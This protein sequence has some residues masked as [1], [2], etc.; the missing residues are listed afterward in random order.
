MVQL[1]LGLTAWFHAGT[2]RLAVG[3]LAF[4]LEKNFRQKVH[5]A[6]SR[7][8]AYTE[9]AISRSLHN[10]R[11]QARW[12]AAMAAWRRMLHVKDLDAIN[13]KRGMCLWAVLASHPL[14]P[15]CPPT[16]YGSVLPLKEN[17]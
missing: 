3:G 7:C 16:D 8:H 13:E 2:T 4:S 15:S 10:I 9:Y 1:F 14:Y 17:P 12:D 11:A 6:F 5:A